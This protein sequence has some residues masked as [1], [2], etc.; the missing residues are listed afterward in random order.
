MPTAIDGIDQSDCVKLLGITFNDKLSFL[1]HVN[2]ILSAVSQRF[3]LLGQL[4]RQGLDM[5]GLDIV[6]KA[7][8]LYKILYAC[9]SFYGFLSQTDIDKFQACLNKAYRFGFTYTPINIHEILE[10]RDEK[11]FFTN[12]E[13]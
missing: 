4:R 1:P 12:P 5:R 10:K 7:I 13:P 3:Y 8:I 6:F 11:L 9:Q 2:S